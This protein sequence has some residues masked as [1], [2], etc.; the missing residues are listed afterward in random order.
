MT[1]I[2]RQSEEMDHTEKTVMSGPC[3][4]QFEGRVGCGNQKVG[5]K[6]R[7]RDACDAGGDGTGQ[8]LLTEG[9]G[10]GGEKLENKRKKKSKYTQVRDETSLRNFEELKI[11]L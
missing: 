10:G 2:M 8:G 9:G 7:F 5:E 11:I 1:T 4:I 6:R 3:F